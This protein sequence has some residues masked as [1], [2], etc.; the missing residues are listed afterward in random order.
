[1]F[2]NI[3]PRHA[4]LN[5]ICLLNEMLSEVNNYT[6]GNGI[7]FLWRQCVCAC[8]HPITHTHTHTHTQDPRGPRNLHT[9]FHL[10]VFSAGD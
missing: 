7:F 9:K 5:M 3:V 1:M 8:A 6:Y 4:I 10:G 2:Q